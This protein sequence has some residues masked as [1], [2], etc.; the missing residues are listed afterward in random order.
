[1]RFADAGPRTWLLAGLAGW[2]VA[3]WLLAVL[4]MGARIARLPDDPDLLA[5]LPT[6]RAAGPERIGPHAQ[7]AET[8][9]RPLFSED[10]RPQPFVMQAEGA[11]EQAPAFDFVLT[12][13]LITPQ[14]RMAIVQPSG[15]G[16]SIRMKLGEWPAEAQGWRLVSVEPRSAVFEGP[17]GQKSM[18]L[19][20]FN[21]T[22]GETPTVVNAEVPANARPV[23]VTVQQPTPATRPAAPATTSR[24]AAAP[25]PAPQPTTPPPA[26]PPTT[27][28]DLAETPMTPEAQMEAIRKR[29]EA[30]RAQ[31]R[32]EAQRQQQ[33]N[34]A[35][36]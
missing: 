27:G 6:P 21:G 35:N 16:E 34:A 3:L 9:T 4:G 18:E 1:V 17:Q 30:R 10:R 15:G 7:Y 28:S 5:R 36:K 19:R 31:L 32:E 24:T 20:T 23:G 29:I 2:A 26:T 13:V 14:V 12:S 33:Q 8:G 11:G 25:A 22:G